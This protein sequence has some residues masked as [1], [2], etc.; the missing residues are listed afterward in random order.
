MAGNAALVL[1]LPGLGDAL[2]AGPILRGRR[3]DSWP[4]RTPTP[5]CPGQRLSSRASASLT[6]LPS[7]PSRPKAA[8]VLAAIAKVAAAALRRLHSAVPGDALAVCGHRPRRRREA[9]RSC[10]TTAARRALIARTHAQRARAAARRAS[11]RRE[12]APRRG[13]LGLHAGERRSRVLGS[14]VL[15]QHAHPG[16]ARH[17]SRLD[18]LE[19]KRGQSAGRTNDFVALARRHAASRTTGSALFWGRTK[20]GSSRAPSKI[21]SGVAGISIIREP[22]AQAA[23]LLAECEVFVG[24]DAGFS[25]L[26]S[27]LGVKTLGA[28][29][30]DERGSRRTDRTGRRDAS[31][32]LSG[33]SRRRV[34]SGFDCV[35]R[36]G[37]PVHCARHRARRGAPNVV[38]E[39]FAAASV[40]Q[41]VSLEGPFK[42][43]GKAYP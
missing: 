22:L 37:V 36:L 42:L 17:P 32:A 6:T 26:A 12:P 3:C 2:A 39:L 8:D 30:H 5:P 14:G 33:L 29:R 9:A 13:A 34:C 7:F 35:R 1:L 41:R 21:F 23:R 20:S 4:H 10:T 16:N 11:H 27:G 40:E 18:G 43:Y 25:H 38:D 31:V 24:N 19:R 15:A 28:L